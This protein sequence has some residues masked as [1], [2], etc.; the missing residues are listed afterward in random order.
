MK[1][2][3]LILI[4]ATI[5]VAF[6][7][8]G[9]VVIPVTSIT[10][11]YHKDNVS[12]TAD[13]SLPANFG[14]QA[15][16][17]LSK[18]SDLD[19]GL[20]FMASTI[21]LGTSYSISP[22]IRK[23][24]KAGDAPIGNIGTTVD[25]GFG[26]LGADIAKLLFNQDKLVSGTIVGIGPFGSIGI[27]GEVFTIALAYKIGIGYASLSIPNQSI[28]GPYF[29]FAVGPQIN[30]MPVRNVGLGAEVTP[31]LGFGLGAVPATPLLRVY[32][33]VTF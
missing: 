6:V 22:F 10:H 7:G 15:S 2:K 9:C 5:F 23:W 8:V 3:L 24:F 29:S 16:L 19:A 26:S 32:L 28:G 33:N 20:G 11:L 12:I 31:S 30:L 1:A 4:L 14:A 18:E 13:Y 17:W 25:I 21:G 27:F